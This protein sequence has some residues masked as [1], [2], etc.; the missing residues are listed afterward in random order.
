MQHLLKTQKNLNEATIGI[1][2][3][4]KIVSDMIKND[5]TAGDW[6]TYNDEQIEALQRT[7]KD[8]EKALHMLGN[9]LEG[10]NKN[11]EEYYNEFTREDFC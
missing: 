4:G 5:L 9:A 8:I 1:I 10:V 7:T 11:L 6:Y 2:A 3:L